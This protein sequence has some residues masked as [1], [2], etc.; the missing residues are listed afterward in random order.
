MTEKNWYA[1]EA[2]DVLKNLEADEKGLSTAEA[3]KRLAQ[4]GKNQLTEAPRPGFLTK[5]WAQLNNFVV[6]L[7]LVAALISGIIGWQ[8]FKHTGDSASFVEP[9][10]KTPGCR[11]SER[12][13]RGPT[14]GHGG[15]PQA[16]R[17]A[18]SC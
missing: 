8:E 6:M 9:G 7:L 11:R 3:E 16:T 18:G 15:S 13:R 2:E 5:L 12:R 14:P 17:D 4:Y 1:L 10:A